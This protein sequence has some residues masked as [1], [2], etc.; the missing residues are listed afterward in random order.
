MSNEQEPLDQ[1]TSFESDLRNRLMLTRTSARYYNAGKTSGFFGDLFNNTYKN[2]LPMLAGSDLEADK[3]PRLL[4]NR[5][6]V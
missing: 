4:V 3:E 5:H 6:A 1:L 2:A